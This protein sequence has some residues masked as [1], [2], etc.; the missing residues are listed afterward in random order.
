MRLSNYIFIMSALLIAATGIL[1]FFAGSLIVDTNRLQQF[2]T[3]VYRFSED[4]HVA[5]LNS[6]KGLDF[7]LWTLNNLRKRL[8]SFSENPNLSLWWIIDPGKN[9]LRETKRLRE[10]VLVFYDFVIEPSQRDIITSYS[11]IRP[12][13]E[14]VMEAF[15]ESVRD[16]IRK[17]EKIA[18]ILLFLLLITVFLIFLFIFYPLLRDIENMNLNR[19]SFLCFKE[20]KERLPAWHKKNNNKKD[21]E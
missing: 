18:F 19:T 2:S 16:A 9:V 5:I 6:E 13:Y 7:D 4:V 20:F 12:S 15:E 10:V 21:G 11:E 14:T 8:S 1:V 3:R 17:G